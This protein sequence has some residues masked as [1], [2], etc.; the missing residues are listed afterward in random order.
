M[1]L[2]EGTRRK[3][4]TRSNTKLI[5]SGGDS[6]A[7]RWKVKQ[8]LPKL[9]DYPYG[10]VGQTDII[11]SKGMMVA[12]D[13]EAG[14]T[15]NYDNDR[16]ITQITLAN[17]T[18]Q[19]IGMAPY[20]FAREVDDRFTGNQPSIITKEYVE[21]PYFPDQADA[22]NNLWGNV[23][24]PIA[25]GDYVKCS[26]VPGLEGR[27][28]KWVEGTDSIMQI[29]GQVLAKEELGTDF[30]FLEWVMW[31]EKYKYGEDTYIN[32]SGYSAPGQEGYPFDPEMYDKNGFNR[33]EYQYLSQYTTLA[34]GVPGLTDGANVR[35]TLLSRTL[36]VAASGTVKDTV[37]SWYIQK[38][39]IPGEFKLMIGATAIAEDDAN[40][41]IE[42][43]KGMVKYT[44]PADLVADASVTLKY[45]AYQYGTP[46]HMD[47]SGADGVVRILLR[48]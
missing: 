31:D 40:L 12:I 47:F 27:L 44:V 25:A 5:V 36:G 8:D 34:T 23:S 30:D 13:S 11:L 15:R 45:K 16:L 17:G 14:M 41:S 39:L 24:G 29:A 22:M 43:K 21:L 42:Y 18:N 6:P 46:S 26:K 28:D 1:A 33:E 20:N 3:P 10:G 35:S 38:D 32:K 9:F 19:V 37:L 48:F 2:F 4:G 7:E